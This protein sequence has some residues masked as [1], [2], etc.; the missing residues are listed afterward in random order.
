MTLVETVVGI[1]LI[2]TVFVGLYGAF[3][4]SVSTVSAAKGE[5][6]ADVLVRSHMEY[7]RSLSYADI[8]NPDSTP[9]GIIPPAFTKVLGGVSYSIQTAVRYVDDP[10]DG[11][12]VS[13]DVNPDDYKMFM[14]TVSWETQRGEQSI[15][16]TS[17][18]APPAM[19]S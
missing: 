8:G 14:V 12:A 6:D 13:G 19:G 5:A 11:L 9:L 15:S 2:V 18:V 3:Q 1:A 10:S 4:L 7:M 16:A 17:Y